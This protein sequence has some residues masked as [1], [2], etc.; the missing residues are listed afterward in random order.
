MLASGKYKPE[1]HLEFLGLNRNP[2]P[3]APDNTDLFLSRHSDTVVNRL[4]EAVLSKKGFMLLTGE[5]GLGKTTLSRRVIEVL[6]KEQVETALILQSF[7][8]GKDLLKEIVRDFGIPL[9]SVSTDLPDLM[10]CLNTFFLEKHKAGINC[11]IL[12]DDAQNLS[13]ESLELV[14]MISNLEADREKLV[15]V[16]LV[17]Q[18]E[19]MD[20]LN[21]HA[22]RQLKSRV[23][24]V[25]TPVPLEKQELEKYLQFKLTMAGD[26]G[27]IVI[28]RTTVDRLYRLTQGN[29]RKINVLM[30]HALATAFKAHS[31]VVQPEYID[32][33]FAHIDFNTP[34]TTP[35]KKWVWG[36][37]TGL[38]L[39]LTGI[40][41]GAGVYYLLPNLS[42]LSTP[43]ALTIF[44]IPLPD[45]KADQTTAPVPDA[46]QDPVPIAPIVS[47]TQT[48]VEPIEL[49]PESSVNIKPLPSAALISFLRAYNLTD[50]APAMAKAI[51]EKQTAD[52]ARQIHA[53]T[54]LQLIQ[55]Q[56]LPDVVKQKYDILTGPGNRPNT[57]SYYL[58]WHPNPQIDHFSF[59]YQGE[60]IILLQQRLKRLGLYAFHIDGIVSQRL[61]KSIE[62][63]QKQMNLDT[64]GFPDP[65]TVFLLANSQ[66]SALEKEKKGI[67]Q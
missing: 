20:T 25:Q 30:D 29:I 53:R 41:A 16:L 58:F 28:K 39:G 7:Y 43:S 32:I 22:L 1:K 44:P 66:N 23:T 10:Q 31:F 18:P 11:M 9:T 65:A 63:F 17:G 59:G 33:A 19:L 15:Q 4:V 24:E 55:L 12:I 3:M 50:F 14:R 47:G 13:V 27:K 45:T 2:F 48:A 36:G 34:K 57:Q 52:I 54:G 42:T 67:R 51:Q 5:I 60:D 64:T 6:E 61:Q 49:A 35:L 62:Q 46:P 26:S 21:T 37:L 56:A 38:I 8:Q 40:L